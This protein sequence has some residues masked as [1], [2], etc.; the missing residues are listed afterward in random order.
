MA[1]DWSTI[2]S[3]ATAG[4]TLVLAAATFVS[5]RA[6]NRTAKASERALLAGIRPV[7]VLSRMEDPVEKV[8]FVD[9]HWLKVP[10]GYGAAEATDEC[11]YLAIGLRNVGNGLAVL[12]RWELTPHLIRGDV[13]RPRPDTFR[14]LTR[15]L[16]VPAGGL[17][18][19]QGAFRDPDDPAFAAVHQA[20][21]DRQPLTLDLLY[22][23]HEGG[24]RTISRFAL[25][26]VGDDRWLASV[27]R[28][29]N[30]DRPDPR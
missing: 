4:A 30:L 5:V 18:F 26:P 2:A 16:Y 25:I 17:G 24:Q 12:D 21:R 8:G 11:V 27:S 7:L 10:G 6:G 28:H 22:G 14:R 20:V 23:D 19:W 1:A 13:E 29:W 15:D 9:N 3:L